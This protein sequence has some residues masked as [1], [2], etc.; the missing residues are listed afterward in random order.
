MVT[1]LT[2]G[3]RATAP[4]MGG[5]VGG[6]LGTAGMAALGPIGIALALASLIK[7]NKA[8]Q[9]EQMKQQGGS[10]PVTGESPFPNLVPPAQ[11][12]SMNF[13]PQQAQNPGMFTPGT[14]DNV[15]LG[16]LG[17]GLSWRN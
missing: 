15:L 6:G 5:A 11:M 10:D 14:V 4:A 3:I 16:R 12:Q 2:G 9:A 1:T 17:R 13:A 8:K 7:G